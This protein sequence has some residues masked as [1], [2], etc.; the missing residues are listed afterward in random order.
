MRHVTARC[1]GVAHRCSIHTLRSCMAGKG[2]AS[3]VP[4]A[5]HNHSLRR[6]KTGKG[7]ASAVPISHKMN[8]ALAPEGR[9]LPP[10]YA[11]EYPCSPAVCPTRRGCP[12]VA[13]TLFHTKI[14]PA[15]RSARPPHAPSITQHSVI[16]TDRRAFAPA[17]VAR[18]KSGFS[19]TSAS[20]PAR[21][22]RE[23]PPTKPSPPP[24]RLHRDFSASLISIKA[25]A[26]LPAPQETTLFWQ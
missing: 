21:Q 12:G 5:L 25:R 16:L 3:A 4:K 10:R 11:R 23:Q 8:G 7:T 20:S 22:C 1:A 17:V 18:D 19:R 2:T 24:P 13:T 15:A 9:V 6:T 14:H 26:A